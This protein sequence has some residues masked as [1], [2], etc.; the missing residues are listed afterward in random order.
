METMT[1][2]KP[3]NF[4]NLRTKAEEILW[5]HPEVVKEFSSQDVMKLLHELRV[6]QTELE[7]QNEELRRAW[8]E[9]YALNEKYH[10]LYDFAPVGYMIIDER[11]LIEDI[12]FTGASLLGSETGLLRQQRFSW[13]VAPGFHD[14]LDSHI[15]LAFKT[16]SRQTCELKLLKNDGTPFY[17]RLESI[18][19]PENARIRMAIIDTDAQKQA[20]EGL[21]YRLGMEELIATI[22]KRFMNAE[23]D[24]FDAEVQRALR[25]VGRFSRSDQSYLCIFSKD[26]ENADQ[27]YEWCEKNVSLH[28]GDIKV[29]L[30][31]S[32]RRSVEKLRQGHHVRVFRV[33]DLLTEISPER[34]LW[35]AAGIES[36]IA[37]PLIVNND[38]A[39]FF[40][41]ISVRTQRKWSGVDGIL[42][43]LMGEIFANAIGRKQKEDSLRDS[44]ARFRAISENAAS[45]IFIHQ[46]DRHVYT[47]PAFEIISGYDRKTLARMSYKDMLPPEMTDPAYSRHEARK[48][49][50]NVPASYRIRIISKKGEARWVDFAIVPV[51]HKEKPAFIGTVSD[52]TDY[53][54]AQEELEQ[55]C[56]KL[57]E[58]QAQLVQSAKLA[59]LGELAAG[60]AHELNQPMTVIRG[61]S[62]LFSNIPDMEGNLNKEELTEICDVIV[63]CT[64]RMT[65]IIRHLRDFSHQSN[66]YFR[67]IDIRE[68]IEN[69][70]LLTG[71]QLTAHNIE[72]KKSLNQDIPDIRADANR[73][74]QVILN[75]ITNARYA[76]EEKQQNMGDGHDENNGFAGY[77]EI[78]AGVNDKYVEI[79]VTDNGTGIPENDTDKIFDPFF[80]TREVGKGTGLGLSISY[81][82]IREHSGDIELLQTGTDGTSFRLKLPV[83]ETFDHSIPRRG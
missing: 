8:S 78:S 34:E 42:I 2:A 44:E 1:T 79:L 43:R 47:N 27:W 59:S 72:V 64:G 70:F 53:V 69:A 60:V 37:I 63:K 41:F 17:A 16:L 4:G 28:S 52:I 80:T 14:T 9:V 22:S 62:Q 7:M 30:T 68:V 57:R 82:I 83:Y 24:G 12:N 81:G 67:R 3:H 5:K 65:R 74:E 20:E 40:G 25:G 56:K 49:G 11:T 33:A 6:H 15:L 75:L 21:R 45:G 50:E 66:S 13:Y 76:I 10:A 19:V 58:T 73:M 51:R 39:G 35:L 32:L 54:S 55:T 77:I 26:G 38:L 18:A 31:A 29:L 23:P 36:L 48:R 71:R 46:D 61:Y